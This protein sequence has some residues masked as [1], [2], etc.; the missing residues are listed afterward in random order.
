[1]VDLLGD[2]G[3]QPQ[4]RV[5]LGPPSRP[6]AG[7]WVRMDGVPVLVVSH[8]ACLGHNAGPGHPERPARIE[9]VLAGIRGVG[10]DD[11]LAWVEARLAT[12]T[13]LAAVHDPAY[14]DAVE[15]FCAAGGGQ[16]DADTTAV[17]GS[18][19]AAIRAAG[20]VLGA[21]EWIEAGQASG[22]FCAV[23][24]P[25][26]HATPDRAMGFCLFN[27]VAAAAASLAARG[28]RVAIL[29]WDVHHGNG[30][31]DAFWTD[32]RVLYV[33][34]H[35]WP[36]YPGTGRLAEVG[37]AEGLGFT[38]NLPLPPGATGDVYLDGFDRVVEPALAAFAPD[39]VLVSCGFDAHRADPLAS[40]ALSAGDYGLFTARASRLAPEGRCVLVLEGGYDLDAL[41]SGAAACVA[42]LA[43]VDHRPA[44]AP[45]SGGPG[46]DVVDAALGLR[47]EL[48]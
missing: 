8:P 22:A 21:V 26:H 41:A 32:P 44:E 3:P 13:E 11:E 10:L 20:A 1:M 33:S 16:I 17:A 27:G 47:D 9:A 24:P 6:R 28:H 18:Y 31:Q 29:D 30:T 39:W 7:R 2:E 48:A 46:R 15:D 42:A 38:V 40:M 36:L 25:G 37:G 19:P 35:Q 23:R 43:G 45:T 4:A 34:W 5:W 12:K 14:V